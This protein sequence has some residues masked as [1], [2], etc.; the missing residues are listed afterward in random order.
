MQPLPALPGRLLPKEMLVY[1]GGGGYRVTHAIEQPV[2]VS[3]AA[4]VGISLAA[5][6]GSAGALL[7]V[8]SACRM[9]S[10][11][12]RFGGKGPRGG[13]L[14]VRHVASSSSSSPVVM[15]D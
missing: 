4:S 9:A 15:S 6:V 14:G 5:G 7:A 10:K 13:H 3:A 2:G 12:K 11:S 1:G 8:A